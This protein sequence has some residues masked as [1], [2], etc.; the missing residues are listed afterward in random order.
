[1]LE[2]LQTTADE[3]NLATKDVGLVPPFV[4]ID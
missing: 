1:V 3:R 2:M 4:V